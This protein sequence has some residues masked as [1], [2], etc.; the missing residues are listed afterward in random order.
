MKTQGKI[1][2][3]D[4]T[5]CKTMKTYGKRQ[6]KNNKKTN[7]DKKTYKSSNIPRKENPKTA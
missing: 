1:K 2:K 3:R 7:N 4:E 5:T 6:I